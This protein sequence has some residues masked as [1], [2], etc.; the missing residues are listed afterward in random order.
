MQTGGIQGG[1]PQLYISTQQQLRNSTADHDWKSIV[2]F[3]YYRS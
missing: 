1:V 3:K 2:S